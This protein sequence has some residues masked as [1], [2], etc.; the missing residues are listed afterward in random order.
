MSLKKLGAATFAVLLI[1]AVMASSAFA[2]ATTTAAEW[3]TGA[4]P[5][6]TLTGS[7]TITAKIGTNGTVGKKFVLKSTIG[8]NNVPVEITAT[9][10]ECVSCSIENKVAAKGGVNTSSSVVATGTGSIKFT[11]VT[12]DTPAN[13]TST[14]R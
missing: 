5:G 14:L 10:V 4:S 13:C 1:G 8:T 2:T 9:G 12:V 6:T 7:K 11:G 3:Y